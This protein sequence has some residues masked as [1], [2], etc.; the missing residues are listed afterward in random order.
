MSSPGGKKLKEDVKM[1][2][3]R[4]TLPIQ[5]TEWAAD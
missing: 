2:K 4:I 1:A 5:Y 3:K